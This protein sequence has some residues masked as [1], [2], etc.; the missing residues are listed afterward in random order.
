MSTIQ[1]YS[2]ELCC[3]SLIQ[4][5]STNYYFLSGATVPTE[6][7]PPTFA[8]EYDRQLLYG[9]ALVAVGREIDDI[10]VFD[11]SILHESEFEA[12]RSMKINKYGPLIEAIRRQK[13]SSSVNFYSMEIGSSLG[14]MTE[15]TKFSIWQFFQITTQSV[16]VD[17]IMSNVS[18]LTKLSSFK[19]FKV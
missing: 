14:Q 12:V 18:L 15:A 5:I 4:G 8:I 11:I 2:T 9:P 17:Q 6:I 10:F 19:L 1:S 16:K 3:K 7:L 13:S